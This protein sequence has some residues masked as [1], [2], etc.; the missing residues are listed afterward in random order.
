MVPIHQNVNNVR[1]RKQ[2][3]GVANSLLSDFTVTLYT[4]PQSMVG[5]VRP[6]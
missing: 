2:D 1:P 4:H 3:S 5:T 6:I